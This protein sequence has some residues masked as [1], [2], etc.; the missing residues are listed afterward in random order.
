MPPSSSTSSSEGSSSAP[1][2]AAPPSAPTISTRNVLISLSLTTLVLVGIGYV[3]FDADVLRQMLRQVD[4]LILGGAVLVTLGRLGAGGWRLSFVSQGRLSLASGTRGQ[5]AWDFFSSVT[6]SAIGG[7]PVTA[8][9]IARDRGITIGE[10]TAFMLFAML[11]DQIWFLLA[12]PL[13]VVAA[14]M[15]PVIPEAVGSIGLWSVL[16]Y[17]GVLVVWASL[18]AYTMLVRPHLLERLAD[19]C[20]GWRYLR[21]F[22]SRVLRE[23]R[24]FARR[25]ERLRAQPLSFYLKG[26]AITGLIW[27]GRYVLIY[28][29]VRSVY[30]QADGVLMVLRTAAMTLLGLIMPTPG[31][32][33]GVEGLYA[34][35]IGPLMPSALVAPTLLTW[36]VLG[37]YLFIALGAYLFWHQVQQ[38][39]RGEASSLHE[40]GTADTEVDADASRSSDPPVAA[41]APALNEADGAGV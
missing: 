27:M 6:P 3:T 37:Y 19:R 7:G 5:L 26:V 35:L 11:L 36:R 29:I 39:M 38:R 8:F 17:F 4:G 1:S 22:R 30:A 34:L 10:A 20:F 41:P 13:L 14:L 32:S 24:A 21:R 23:M 25:A 33:G 31:G 18:F 12:I 9:Y 16:A 2:E 28:L 40:N 15:L